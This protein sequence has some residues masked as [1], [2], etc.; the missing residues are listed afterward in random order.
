[1]ADEPLEIVLREVILKALIASPPISAKWPGG[2]PNPFDLAAERIVNELSAT[3]FLPLK[4]TYA[5]ASLNVHAV[6]YTMTRLR[7]RLLKHIK[8]GGLDMEAEAQA[9]R[10]ITLAFFRDLDEHGWRLIRT[11]LGTKS[12]GE[13][14]RP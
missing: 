13:T 10:D 3:G 11:H 5:D 6:S 7:S 8:G 1:M 9:M 12:H 2:T 14:F 4:E